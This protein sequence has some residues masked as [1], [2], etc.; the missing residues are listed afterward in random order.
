[1]KSSPKPSK[2]KVVT[3]KPGRDDRGFFVPG[4]KLSK[5]TLGGRAV[6]ARRWL[7]GATHDQ[8]GGASIAQ[9]FEEGIIAWAGRFRTGEPPQFGDE[10][11]LKLVAPYIMGDMGKKVDVEINNN[12]MQIFAVASQRLDDG[13]KGRVQSLLDSNIAD[14]FA[15]SGDEDEDGA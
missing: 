1:M 4:N 3:P 6:L 13:A 12:T 8:L 10:S 14:A 2:A 11:I 9:C 15:R 5:R 7:C